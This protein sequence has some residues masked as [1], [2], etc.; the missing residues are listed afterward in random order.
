M[1]MH[2]SIPP[3]QSGLYDIPRFRLERTRREAA[4]RASV[5]IWSGHPSAA[6]CW[7]QVVAD[8]DERLCDRRTA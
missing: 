3:R 2:A 8:C 4:D 7:I 1:K 6:K 5:A